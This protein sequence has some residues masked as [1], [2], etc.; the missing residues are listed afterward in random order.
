MTLTKLR[1][2][3][4]TTITKITDILH[5]APKLDA[6]QNMELIHAYEMLEL[7]DAF[8]TYKEIVVRRQNQGW[9]LVEKVIAE[10]IAELKGN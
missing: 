10:H 9:E 4:N 5:F 8:I 7:L 2:K 6:A 3:R 1:A